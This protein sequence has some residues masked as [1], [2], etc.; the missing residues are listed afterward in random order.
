MANIIELKD[1]NFSAQHG[2]VL[3]NVSINFAEGKTT[4][5]VGPSGGG[6]STVLKI[7]AGILVPDDGE[8]LYKN[9]D[10]S[11]MNRAENLLFRRETAF[12][13]QSSA[14]W[15]NQNIFQ[16]LELPLRIHF[17]HMSGKDR[18]K[19]IK[20]VVNE[21]GYRRDLDIRPSRLS[22]GEQKLIAFARALL[23]KP[24]LLFLDEWTESLD[25]T[26]SR[27]LIDIVKQMQSE[28]FTIICISHD[29]KLVL[30]LADHVIIIIDGKV[31]LK[32]PKDDI[33]DDL[34]DLLR[35][36]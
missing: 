30:E 31:S 16:I 28:G 13:F 17:P 32:A 24:S 18:F 19:R 5:V 10:I 36:G 3:S 33:K 9:K 29:I 35:K 22:M 4:A 25:K 26:G 20:E 15:A 27:R 21:V 11:H 12:V 8:A 6:K 7:S 1:I 34:S 14:L 2:K 23:C